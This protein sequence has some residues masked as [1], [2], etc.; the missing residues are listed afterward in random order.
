[1][2]T[3]HDNSTLQKDNAPRESWEIIGVLPNA[4]PFAPIE[5]LT[6]PTSPVAPWGE[7]PGMRG[8]SR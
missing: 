5:S 1:M 6:P 2:N 8:L 7:G 3:N 4:V